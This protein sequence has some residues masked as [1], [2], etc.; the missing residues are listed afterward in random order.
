MARYD[1]NLA[2]K[3]PLTQ[4]PIPAPAFDPLE[5]ERKQRAKAKAEL[6]RRQKAK[7]TYRALSSLRVKKAI[8]IASVVLIAAFLIAIP[9]WRYAGIMEA[10]YQNVR[11]QNEIRRLQQDI[12]VRDGQMLEIS[13]LMHV[14]DLAFKSFGMQTQTAEQTL[15]LATSSKAALAVSQLNDALN[16]PAV[17]IE[18]YVK[19]GR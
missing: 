19:S 1:G 6:V 4:M 3:L 15:S 10:N 13:D 18:Q 7:Q 14:R 12:N 16:D 2:Y 8:A 11:I 5:E 9:V 17:T